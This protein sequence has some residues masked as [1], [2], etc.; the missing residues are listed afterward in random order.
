MYKIE[1]DVKIPLKGK[2]TILVSQSRS[3]TMKISIV[4]I[5]ISNNCLL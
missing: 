2:W 3:H 1:K 4:L 5:P